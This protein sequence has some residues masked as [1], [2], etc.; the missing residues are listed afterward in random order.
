MALKIVHCRFWTFSHTDLKIG[1]VIAHSSKK[2]TSKGS[3][4]GVKHYKVLFC[5]LNP[6][7]EIWHEEGS[8]KKS[9]SKVSSEGVKD[10]I[11]SFLYTKPYRLEI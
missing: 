4:G 5:T 11:L 2:S 10:R 8:S 6:R 1:M 3:C 7:I 9:T